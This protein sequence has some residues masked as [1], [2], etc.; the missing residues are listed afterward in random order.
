MNTLFTNSLDGTRIAYEQS[1]SGGTIILIHGGGGSRQEWHDA[2]YVRRLQDNFTVIAMDLRGHGESGLPTDPADYTTDKMGQD[3]LAVAD[4]CGVDCFSIWGMSFGSKVGRY[5][6]VQNERVTRLILM[7][8]Q[9]GLG[10]S[11]KLRQ[12]AFE[13]C[14]H[15]PPIL[16]AIQAGTVKFDSLI[17]EDR[18]V[19]DRLNVPVMLAWV[20]AMLDWPAIEPVDFRCPTLWLAGS[21]DQPAIESIQKYEDSLKGSMVKVHIVDGLDHNE[22]FDQ[23]DLVFPKMLAFTK[24][25]S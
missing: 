7:G 22:L 13:F 4:A 3:I 23:I 6:A 19:L 18:D 24:N 16:K 20:R 9:L 11:G 17:P 15:W 12:D 8:A 2:G 1:G 25:P 21:K 5:L 10:V 14:N